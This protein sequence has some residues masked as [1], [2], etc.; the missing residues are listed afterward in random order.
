MSKRL[1]MQMLV[2]GWVIALLTTGCG[3]QEPAVPLQPVIDLCVR[4]AGKEL[5]FVIVKSGDRREDFGVI[6]VGAGKT[7]GFGRGTIG[8]TITV[9][10]S[11]DRLNAPQQ[12]AEVPVPALTGTW[13]ELAVEH[14]ADGTWTATWTEQK[15]P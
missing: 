13:G 2:L 9:Q 14:Q 7:I 1:Q 6:G 8:A 12:T 5:L 10:W 11:I 3:G 15:N 4:N